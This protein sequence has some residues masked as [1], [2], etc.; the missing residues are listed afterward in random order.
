MW[1][2]MTEA[3]H[4]VT[5]AI[6]HLRAVGF[7]WAEIGAEIGWSK[8]RLCPVEAAPGRVPASTVR[9]RRNAG[10]RG[11]GMTGEAR[12]R[13]GAAERGCYVFP[14]RPGKK[15]PAV[16]ATGNTG[17]APTLNGCAGSGRA[18]G[19]TSASPAGPRGSWWS[20]WTATA[21]CRTEWQHARHPR[22]PGRPRPAVRVGGAA[23]AVHSL[24]RRH[25]LRRLAPV[26][27]R[28]GRREIRNSAGMIGPQVDVRACGGY[29]VGAGSVIDGTR[30]R[31]ASTTPAR[32]RCPSWIAAHAHP[33]SR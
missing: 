5:E 20:T 8:Q 4:A 27:P 17:H 32:R 15:R 24:G 23:L 31:G 1:E 28:P 3:E 2:V 21:S 7:S 12:C 11:G 22:R 6:D 25:G 14:C 33:P 26:L 13:A 19:T 9:L 10:I 18:R 29:V 16:P 30:L